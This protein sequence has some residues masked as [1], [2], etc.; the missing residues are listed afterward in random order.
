MS[1]LQIYSYKKTGP[2]IFHYKV[3][4]LFCTFLESKCPTVQGRNDGSNDI[5]G[6]LQQDYPTT[7]TM[8]SSSTDTLSRAKVI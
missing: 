6:A 5:I 4:G 2:C 1:K 7:T 8:S 3:I